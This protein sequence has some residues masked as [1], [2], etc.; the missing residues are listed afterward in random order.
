[1]KEKLKN[2]TEETPEEVI[3]FIKKIKSPEYWEKNV[4]DSDRN[5]NKR[6]LYKKR[7]LELFEKNIK[8]K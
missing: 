1:M 2:T 7:L 3:N 5:Q 8:N 4:T 6:L